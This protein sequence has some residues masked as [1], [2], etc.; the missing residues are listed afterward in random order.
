M[1]VKLDTQ[2]KKMN[3]IIWIVGLAFASFLGIGA[4]QLVNFGQVREQTLTNTEDINKIRNDYIPYFAVQYI[5]ESNNKLI[6]LL[7]A[8]ESKD[9]HRYQEAMRDWQKLQQE[10]VRNAGINKRSGGTSSISGGQ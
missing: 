4:V 6:N 2:D 3:I 10:V 9:D 7:T 1:T 5:V 8:I